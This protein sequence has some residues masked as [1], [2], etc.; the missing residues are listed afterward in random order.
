MSTSSTRL[1]NRLESVNHALSLTYQFLLALDHLDETGTLDSEA[2]FALT[3]LVTTARNDARIVG[4]ALP[5]P[6]RCFE[7]LDDY[8]VAIAAAPPLQPIVDAHRKRVNEE[9]FAVAM[10]GRSRNDARGTYARR[11]QR[12]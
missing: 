8:E 7:V 2:V 6:L 11:P 9:A 5:E 3:A 12:Q 4:D 1:D 10:H